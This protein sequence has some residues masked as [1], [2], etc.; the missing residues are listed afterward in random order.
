MI[1]VKNLMA[2]LDQLGQQADGDSPRAR[3]LDIITDILPHG[4][5]K[6]PE[7]RAI[8]ASEGY[9]ADRALRGVIDGE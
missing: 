6:T 3:A 1:V 7:G 4:L 2:M 5:P 8:M 9:A